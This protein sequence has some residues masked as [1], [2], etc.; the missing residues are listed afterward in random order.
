MRQL[1]VRINEVQYVGLLNHPAFSLWDEGKIL[2]ATLY[3]SFR[4][5]NVKLGDI[6]VAG[7]ATSPAN[8]E[9]SVR[10]GSG[11]SFKFHF[12]RLEASLANT[13]GNGHH[14]WTPRTNRAR[15]RKTP[16]APKRLRGNDLRFM[17]L[18]RVELPTS[19]LSGVR[20]NHLSYRP[21]ATAN[22]L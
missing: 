18:G 15:K 10:L 11:A 7:D 17:G 20:S 13:P 16:P 12:D 19:R 1:E 21:Y 9:V 5:F 2:L 3:N 6:T 4:P 22:S 14:E 8:Q